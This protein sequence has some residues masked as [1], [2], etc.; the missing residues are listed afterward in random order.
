MPRSGFGSAPIAFL[1]AASPLELLYEQCGKS[2]SLTRLQ[3]SPLTS[4]MSDLFWFSPQHW[5]IAVLGQPQVAR[6][7]PCCRVP[8]A[9]AGAAT[10]PVSSFNGRRSNLT[11]THRAHFS[12]GRQPR[13][14][15]A[16]R[17]ELGG[18]DLLA[19]GGAARR[20]VSA[21]CGTR[22]HGAWPEMP[23]STA[24]SVQSMAEVIGHCQ[25]LDAP[26]AGQAVADEVHAPDLIDAVGQLQWHALR[27]RP[28]GLVAPSIHTGILS[29]SAA[30]L[31]SP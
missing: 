11:K 7:L 14:P 19:F 15:V 4:F 31:A 21:A 13:R 28:L 6:R 30:S 1:T 29:R 10:A 24:R 26:P 20:T 23:Q 16:G 2:R 8:P 27:S 9:L 25:A 17:F 5:I 12:L 3:C 22:C 18:S